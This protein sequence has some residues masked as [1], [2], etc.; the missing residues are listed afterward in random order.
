[1]KYSPSRAPSSSCASLLRSQLQYSPVCTSGPVVCR[2]R[3]RPNPSFCFPN[4]HYNLNHLHLGPPRSQRRFCGCVFLLRSPEPIVTLDWIYFW[5]RDIGC[6]PVLVLLSMKPC[7]NGLA[8]HTHPEVWLVST[9]KWKSIPENPSM[10]SMLQRVQY[11]FFFTYALQPLR[12]IVRS[13]LD[14]STFATRRVHACHYARA[15]SGGRW[16]CW[17]EMS[18]NFA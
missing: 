13:W 11:V 2:G 4:V 9:C 14:V 10:F 3:W 17:R 8:C 18:G 7:F 5:G 16:N 12:R 6:V 15:P 1:M